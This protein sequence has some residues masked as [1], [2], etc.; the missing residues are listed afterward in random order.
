[1]TNLPLAL[2]NIQQGWSSDFDFTRFGDVFADV[3][4]PP[5]LIMINEAVQ[6]WANLGRGKYAAA[7]AL[8][9]M[10]GVHYAIEIGWLD[11]SDHPPALVYDTARLQLT[12]W[13]NEHSCTNTAL[14][15]TA[16]FVLADSGKGPSDPP[17][18]RVRLQH[19]HFSSATRRLAEA[20]ILAA[21]ARQDV[22][23]IVA[24][25]LNA[26]ASGPHL[27]DRDWDRV[28][29]R[30]PQRLRRKAWQPGGAGTP[31]VAD[32][33]A[34]DTLIGA[35]NPE[36]GQREDNPG[37]YALAEDDW[38][39]RGAR[40]DDTL[41]GTTNTRGERDGGLL[42]DWILRNELVEL[43]PDTYRVHI[44]APG[45]QHTDHRLVTATVQMSAS[46]S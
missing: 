9:R 7:L 42:I 33:R 30:A 27:P 28:R 39:Q 22:P 45:R 11:R 13:A 5:A 46:R 14:R 34:V 29:E 35:W 20:E 10:F 37:L 36:T 31:W 4:D 38:H 21:Q 23:T 41:V 12:A 6:W 3:S 25:D 1:M 43:V 15:N 24:G 17:D 2:L 8:S 32:T 26:T 16:E 40:P 18:L 19:F 44:P